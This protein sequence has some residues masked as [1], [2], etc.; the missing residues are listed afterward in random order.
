[1]TATIHEEIDCSQTDGMYQPLR[2]WSV[3][4]RCCG[5][6]SCGNSRCVV[7]ESDRES[8]AASHREVVDMLV[9]A[10]FQ[11]AVNVWERADLWARIFC[12]PNSRSL[13]VEIGKHPW[14]PTYTRRQLYRVRRDATMPDE[15][16]E[17]VCR[18][19]LIDHLSPTLKVTISR[20]MARGLSREGIMLLVMD[21]VKRAVADG[22]GEGGE[23]TITAVEAYLATR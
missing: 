4:W 8:N 15:P 1:M 7:T 16:L 12:D 6:S 14:T 11:G 10:G 20:L 5:N 17:D 19:L 9:A 21:S 2:P 3:Q 18:Q 23:L 22:C 13:G